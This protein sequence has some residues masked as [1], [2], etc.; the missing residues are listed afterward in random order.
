MRFGLFGT[1][2]ISST[3]VK[4]FK[5]LGYPIE[6]VYGSNLK[7]LEHFA[8]KN[9]IPNYSNNIKNLILNKKINNFIIANDPSQHLDLAKILIKEKKNILIEKPLDV[10][11]KKIK[12]FCKLI[13]NKRNVIHVVNQN[14]FDPFYIKLREEIM[15]QINLFKKKTKYANLNMFFYRGNEYFNSTNGWKKYYSCPMLNQGIHF[16]DLMIWF[17]GDVVEVKSLTQ[18]NNNQ[19]KLDDNVIGSI[20]FKNNVLLNI[21]SSTS[22]KRNEIKFEFFCENVLIKFEKNNSFSRIKNFLFNSRSQFDLFLYQSEFFI[23]SIKEKKLKN[24]NVIDAYKAVKLA[25]ELNK[26]YT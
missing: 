25:K 3:Y 10:S 9:K 18:K 24:N 5:K 26:T 14:R 19:L 7:R 22:L 15:R 1:S 21:F 17:F 12:N 11:L 2:N 20:R 8:K 6:I 4:C 16:L 23:K 13:Q